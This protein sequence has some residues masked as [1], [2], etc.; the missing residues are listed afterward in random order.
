MHCHER[1]PTKGEVSVS[2]CD[3]S[4]LF[5]CLQAR[6]L[7]P[8]IFPSLCV[9]YSKASASLTTISILFAVCY[10]EILRGRQ[11]A[12]RMCVRMCVCVHLLVCACSSSLGW[13]T[14][15]LLPEN[16][17]YPLLLYIL[18]ASSNQI[19]G[20]N[21]CVCV[22]LYIYIHVHAHTCSWEWETDVCWFDKFAMQTQP[23][24]TDRNV[25]PNR[26]P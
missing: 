6:P 26:Q 20:V 19:P 1:L 25:I 5:H 15:T 24:L 10:S 13:K 14:L 21:M 9:S 4:W 18:K 12:G 3:R 16:R 23:N 11:G 8:S 7:C 2:L 22:F 17:S